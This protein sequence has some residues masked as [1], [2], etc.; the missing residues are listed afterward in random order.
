MMPD[1]SR[2]VPF[3]EYPVEVRPVLGVRYCTVCGVVGEP[4]SRYEHGWLLWADEPFT[5]AIVAREMTSLG[6]QVI[7][8]SG[9]QNP[10]QP[11]SAAISAGPPH[12][13]DIYVG[14]FDRDCASIGWVGLWSR[15]AG[16]VVHDMSE[17]RWQAVDAD[18]VLYEQRDLYELPRDDV[19]ILTAAQATGLAIV[20]GQRLP[21]A[22]EI[23]A[24]VRTAE[25]ADWS[26]TQL[27]QRFHDHRAQLF[28]DEV[29]RLRAEGARLGDTPPH[30]QT[31][32]FVHDRDRV[33][34]GIPGLPVRVGAPFPLL[35]FL[36]GTFH[37]RTTGR[38][39]YGSCTVVGTGSTS[40]PRPATA[41]NSPCR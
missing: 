13:A 37:D 36:V 32:P 3:R 15:R 20:A 1:G 35:R 11:W 8:V 21:T 29:Q 2:V 19:V 25:Q 4:G 22:T 10:Q 18:Q 26:R 14:I 27:W 24:T 40:P 16:R 39:G 12:W 31:A 38:S 33:V 28:A 17:Q 34:A 30:R 23:T 9:A 6:F 41:S 7:E 5:A